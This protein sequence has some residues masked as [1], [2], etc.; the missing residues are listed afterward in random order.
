MEGQNSTQPTGGI[1]QVLRVA[2]PLIMAS[3]GHAFRLFADR[4]MLA[5]YSQ[6]AIA[7]AMPAGLT[8]FCL[9]CFFLGT[10]GYAGTFVAQYAGANQTKRTGLAVWQG[11][12]I[13]LAGGLIVGMSAPAAHLIFAWMGHSEGVQEQQVIYFQVLARLSFA[14][15]LLA[16]LNSFWSGRGKTTV[17]MMIELVCAAAN[18]LLNHMLI[19]GNWGCPEL[20]I[21]G[22]GLA[23]GLSTMLGLAIAL[24]LFFSP[25]NRQRY[26]TL[27]RRTLDLP[28]LRRLLHFGSPN[29]IQFALDLMAFNLFVILLGRLGTVELEA[30]NMAFAINAM[31]Y[32]PLIGL[33][34]TVSILVG[35]GIGGQCLVAARRT[36]R[37]ALILALI[38]NTVVAVVMLAFPRALLV[39]FAR[40]DDPAQLQALET[41]IVYMRYITAY[42][43][44]DGFYIVFSHAI[45]G[46]GDTRFAMWAGL[47]MSW[48][49]LVLP[50][51]IAQHTGASG[52][53]FWSI[54]VVH[55]LLAGSVFLARYLAGNW[56]RMRVIEEV[57]TA[58]I[59]IQADRGI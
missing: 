4:V 17:V 39:L 42:L 21:L 50:C 26:G 43:V 19:S 47:S 29:G 11:I 24:I 41:A 22:A 28:L 5:R 2:F 12:Y 36:V 49:T 25:A 51:F 34:M 32:L 8:C 14:P 57:P 58:E 54:L 56:M 38:C 48:G 6:D 23:T 44:F 15:I 59:E 31:V 7:A 20:G 33:G 13:A 55:V 16:T 46:A 10:A 27:P 53:V 40:P 9:M 45:R 18:I 37:S 1:G 35:Q 52:H 30:A 3:S